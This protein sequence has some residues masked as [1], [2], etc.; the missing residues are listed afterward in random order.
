M[1]ALAIAGVAVVVLGGNLLFWMFVRGG[2]QQRMPSPLDDP[3]N[4]PYALWP[5]I[6]QEES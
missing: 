2:T 3:L 1:K 4:R 5:E 6:T